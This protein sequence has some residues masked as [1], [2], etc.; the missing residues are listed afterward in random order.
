MRPAYT[1]QSRVEQL[2]AWP[3]ACPTSFARL[4]INPVDNFSLFTP[5]RAFEEYA[6]S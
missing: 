2:H 3:W 5:T 1:P 4:W 6:E